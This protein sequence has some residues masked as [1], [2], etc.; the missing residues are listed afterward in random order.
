MTTIP[1][2]FFSA[3]ALLSILGLAVLALPRP[4]SAAPRTALV[5]GNAAYQSAPLRNPVNDAS[6]MAAALRKL[7]FDVTLLKD[8]T[9]QQM[10]GAVRDF[11]LKLR[12]G[13]LGLFFF[14]GHGLQV[15]GEN[16]LVPVNAVIQSEGDVKYGCLNAGLVLAKMEDAGNG[17]NV[18][19]LDACRN[20]PFAR[21]FRSAEAGLARMD[22]PTGSIIAYATAPG[23]V[24]ADGEGKNGL[25]TQ[26]LLRHIATPGL[27]VTDLFMNVREAVVRDSARK[28]VPW[29]NTSLIGRFS[30]AGQAAPPAPIAALIAAPAPAPQPAQPGQSALPVVRPKTAP[31]PTPEEAQLLQ[32]MRNPIGRDPEQVRK[33]ARPLAAKGS[34]YG[35]FALGWLNGDEKENRRAIAQAADQGIALAMSHHAYFL[36]YDLA[37][38]ED[39][40]E[41][42]AWLRHAAGLGEPWAKLWLGDLLIRGLGGPKDVAAGERLFSE[43]LREDMALS[44]E[45]GSKYFSYAKS[46]L[47]KEA[48]EAKG[49]AAWKRGAEY[50]EAHNMVL[51]GNLYRR[52]QFGV[53]A[54]AR[55]AHDWFLRA[56]KKGDAEG[57][58]ALGGLLLNGR[59]PVAQDQAAAAQWFRKASE[60]G[61]ESGTILLAQCYL[62]G[63]GVGKDVQRGLAML[64]GLAE[65]GSGF[66]QT[67][68]GDV[69]LLGQGVPEDVSEAYFWYVVAARAED[70]WGQAKRGQTVEKLSAEQRAKIEARAA[71]WKPK[72]AK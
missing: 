49:L 60:S 47:P 30:F 3:C 16:Y 53:R 18:V 55:E 68:L 56:A 1:H 72:E 71:K 28:Q 36:A 69:Y 19:I 62:E 7:G 22:A 50:G 21:S 46:F 51:L 15:A 11:G 10:E 37:T 23:K 54:D 25:Y 12:K 8:A 5:I 2:R 43:I 24:A 17:P 31:A 64:K 29:E 63:E 66:A 35:Q 32:A 34:L 59:E 42:R 44:G 45:V 61:Y 70:F 33:L 39:Q 4:A 20:N 58:I 9:M 48:A 67:T 65:K 13:G 27:S 52:S 6:D 38:P 57:M 41:A 26:H 14:A 40:A